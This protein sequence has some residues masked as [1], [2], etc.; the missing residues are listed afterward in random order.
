MKHVR[1]P[2]DHSLERPILETLAYSDIFDYPLRLDELH[3]Y[4]TVPAARADITSA[5]ADLH[6]H[7][8]ERD[9]FYFLVGRDVIVELRKGRESLAR[10]LFDL[11]LRYGRVIGRLPFIRMAALTG[12]L[13]LLNVLTGADFDF[14]LIAARGRV[15]TA[16]AFALA[17]GR[18]ARG[19][20]HTLCPNL[21]LS[22]TALAWPLHDLYSAREFCQMIPITGFDSYH[23]LRAAN[24][25]TSDFLPNALDAPNEKFS[26]ENSRHSPIRDIRV[27]SRMNLLELPLRASLGERLERWEMTRKIAR[28]SC[29]P[30]FGEET[31]FNAE[32]C[33]GNFHHHRKWTR[34]AY[35]ERLANLGIDNMDSKV[36]R[37]WSEPQIQNLEILESAFSSEIGVR[38]EVAS[39]SPDYGRGVRGEGR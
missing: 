12:S 19:L 17:V 24:Q 14:M 37:L 23:R 26:K 9:G 8:D 10:P 31:V 30:G 34:Q 21:I 35:E 5:L 15:W 16:R 7:V 4:L 6:G 32:V 22:E 33:Q 38:G 28:L 27:K 18:V 11:A 36:S 25:W 29:Q 39:P 13:A 3:R 20:G 2:F 1:S